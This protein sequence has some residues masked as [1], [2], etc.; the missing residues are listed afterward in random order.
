MKTKTD[1]MEKTTDTST[2]T[3]AETTQEEV[4]KEEY[5]ENAENGEATIIEVSYNV[6]RFVHLKV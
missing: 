5:N 4:V 2:K 6:N 3:I 1:M